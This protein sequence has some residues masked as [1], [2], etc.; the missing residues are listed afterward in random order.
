MDDEIRLPVFKKMIE[1]GKIQKT[2]EQFGEK[3]YIEFLIK[4][5]AR[6]WKRNRR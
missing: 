2:I 1:N 5:K 4:K 6:K 3:K